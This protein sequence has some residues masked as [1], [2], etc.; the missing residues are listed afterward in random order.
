MP[1]SSTLYL[2][3]A[4][5]VLP[6]VLLAWLGYRYGYAQRVTA[7]GLFWRTLLYCAALSWSLTG[8]LSHDAAWGLVL[9]AALIWTFIGADAYALPPLWVTPALQVFVYLAAVFWG[10]HRRQATYVPLP[11]ADGGAG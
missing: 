1:E 10:Y 6:A 8:G 3:L 5:L 2:V 11:S 4:L 7:I 9:P